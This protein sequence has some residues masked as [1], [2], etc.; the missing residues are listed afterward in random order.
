MI[1]CF[2]SWI[3]LITGVFIREGNR[4]AQKE[5]SKKILHRLFPIVS[6]YTPLKKNGLWA[7]YLGSFIRQF[8]I[9]GTMA[10][11]LIF[12]TEN[13]LLSYSLA[14]LLSSLNP[15][16]QMISHLMSGK[17]ITKTGPRKSMVGG[18]LFSSLTPILFFLATD[19]RLM[20]AGY[21][22]LGLA[23]GA[24]INGA[25]TFISLN[26]PPERKAEFMGLLTSMRSLGAMIGPVFS[27]II[28]NYSF[29]WMFIIMNIIMVF[30]AMMVLLNTKE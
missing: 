30:A 27:G 9:S 22:S 19:W 6:D 26:C 20:A 23:Y 1:F 13:L 21:I 15:M 5:K 17:I 18:I 14:V 10:A 7:I 4:K 8:G 11:I 24:F 25:S 29:D 28:A 3:P 16:F 2:I 12:M